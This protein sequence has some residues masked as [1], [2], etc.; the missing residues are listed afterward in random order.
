M[1]ETFVEFVDTCLTQVRSP[2]LPARMRVF[3]LLPCSERCLTLLPA[4]CKCCSY[5]ASSQL[6]VAWT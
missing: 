5:S 2:T 3:A 6:W 4:R 1:D